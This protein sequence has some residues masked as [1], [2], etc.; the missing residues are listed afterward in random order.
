MYTKIKKVI[1]HSIKS[2]YW[3][4]QI[5]FYDYQRKRRNYCKNPVASHIPVFIGIS[6]IIKIH[7]ILELGSGNYS[8]PLFLDKQIFPDLEFVV[9]YENDILWY[10]EI[11]QKFLN[12]DRLKLKYCDALMKDIV[13]DLDISEFDLIFVDDSRE[14][15]LRSQT[16]ECISKKINNKNFLAIHDFE[17]KAYKE[18]TGTE[19]KK[20]KFDAI[21]PNTGLAWRNKEINKNYFSKINKLIK[22]NSSL[23]IPEDIQFWN[24]L[25]KVNLL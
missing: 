17:V 21:F 6:K 19:L 5:K 4:L 12:E 2:F 9:S 11:K 15:K 20:F 7:K 1:P 24:N 10:N 23:G 8:T 16:I 22:K 14:A 3:K 25:F 18:A 13:K